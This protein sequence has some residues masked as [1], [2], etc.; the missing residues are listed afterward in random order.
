[1][2]R[3]FWTPRAGWRQ[4]QQ[5][6]IFIPSNALKIAERHNTTL[7]TVVQRAIKVFLVIDQTI[8]DQEMMVLE[9]RGI[10]AEIQMFSNW[11]VFLAKVYRGLM[12]SF[13]RDLKL[14]VQYPIGD[15]LFGQLQEIAN[16]HRM[17]VQEVCKQL[18]FVFL[19]LEHEVSMNS[20]NIVHVKRGQIRDVINLF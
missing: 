17:S 10:H 1:M 8:R 6:Y 4:R 18:W 12:P 3:R 16:Q 5:R 13:L 7:E 19:V 2:F 9:T 14:N 11:P 20:A 15:I